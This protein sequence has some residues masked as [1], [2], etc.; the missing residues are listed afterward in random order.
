[1]RI[2]QTYLDFDAQ[3]ET[4]EAYLTE[5][6]RTRLGV[7]DAQN[8]EFTTLK[9]TWDSA[10]SDYKDPAT[11]TP[12]AVMAMGESYSETAEFI[13]ALR[14]QI[15]NNAS[16]TLTPDDYANLYI[17]VDKTTRSRINPPDY[18]PSV[19]LIESTHLVCK[20]DVTVPTSE[21]VNHLALPAHMNIARLLAVMPDGTD[22]TENDYEPIDNVGRSKFSLSF[23]PAEEGMQGYLICSYFNPRGEH[24]PQSSPLKFRII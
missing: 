8:T 3:L 22:P 5:A 11:H 6:N 14:Q 18:A 2:S 21:E 10:L 23:M 15:K 24:G 17:H 16:I 4:M 1:M 13:F 9:A 7:S 19:T 12:T 20:F